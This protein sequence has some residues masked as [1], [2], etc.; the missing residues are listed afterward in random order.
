MYVYDMAGPVGSPVACASWRKRNNEQPRMVRRQGRPPPTSRGVV[1]YDAPALHASTLMGGHF[2]HDIL[3]NYFFAYSTFWQA[4][5]TVNLY[6]I[7]KSTRPGSS[8]KGRKN[9]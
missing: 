9:R 5:L 8:R 3:Q 6:A 7:K 2:G 4:N 1:W